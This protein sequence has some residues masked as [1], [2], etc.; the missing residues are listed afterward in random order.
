VIPAAVVLVASLA[1]QGPA[2]AVEGVVRSAATDLPIPYAQVRIAGDSLV[3]WTSDAGAYRL[4]GLPAGRRRIRVVHPG[5]EP[6]DVEV[7]VPGD[8]S[9][10]LDIVLEPRPGPT[11][12]ALSDF[13]PFQVAYTLPALLNADTVAAMIRQRYPP[14]LVDA[15]IGGETV[16]RL[17]LD[18]RGRVVRSLL[19]S[20]SGQPPLDS[21]ALAVADQ[22]RFRPAKNRDQA[23]RVIVRMPVVFTVPESSP[24]PGRSQG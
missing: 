20:S 3:D 1:A 9:L 15:G 10:H 17:W 16:L 19:S 5:H 12:D 22:M 21:V 8:R 14:D 7:V 24:D 6:F 4:E 13:E 23:V 2:P 11:V 18:E